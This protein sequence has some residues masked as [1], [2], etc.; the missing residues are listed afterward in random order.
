MKKNV[1]SSQFRSDS[2]DL[3]INVFEIDPLILEHS[4]RRDHTLRLFY[5]FFFL[6]NKFEVKRFE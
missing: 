1:L 2:D 5:R 4:F 3:R 6:S